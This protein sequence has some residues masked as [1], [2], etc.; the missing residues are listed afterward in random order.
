MLWTIIKTIGKVI[1][2]L[3][4][5]PAVVIGLHEIWKKKK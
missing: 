5:I 1:E 3:T 2:T 4:V